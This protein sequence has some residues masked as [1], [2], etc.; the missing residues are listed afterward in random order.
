[1]CIDYEL[2]GDRSECKLRYQNYLSFLI[3]NM[4]WEVSSCQVTDWETHIYNNSDGDISPAYFAREKYVVALKTQLWHLN[5]THAQFKNET[6]M[7]AS[8]TIKQQHA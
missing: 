6:C 2:D 5:K 1:M 7:D 4:T 3:V 8:F